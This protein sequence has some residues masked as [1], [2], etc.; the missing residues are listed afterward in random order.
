MQRN[1]I[2]IADMPAQRPKHG[3]SKR[4]IAVG[5]IGDNAKC[6]NSA[7]LA[8][9]GN[10]IW[11][12]KLFRSRTNAPTNIQDYLMPT[13]SQAFLNVRNP[14]QAQA[15]SVRVRAFNKRQNLHGLILQV[16]QLRNITLLRD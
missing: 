15:T 3:W 9:R 4:P 16:S 6:T 7:L 1:K 10:D 13:L 12:N 11:L 5:W 8:E 2:R 14:N